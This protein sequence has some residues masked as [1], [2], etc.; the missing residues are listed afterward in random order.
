MPSNTLIMLASTIIV[1]DFM[2]E[3]TGESLCVKSGLFSKTL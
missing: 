3:M 2:L 1:R